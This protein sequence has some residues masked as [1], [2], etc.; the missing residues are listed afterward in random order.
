MRIS[1][2]CSMALHILVLLG[3]FPDKKS[4]S[5]QIAKSV[6]SNPVMVR[7]LLGDLRKAGLLSTQRGIGGSAL[8]KNPEEITLWM[9]YQAV[10]GNSFEDFIGLHPNPSPQCPVGKKIYSLLEEPYNKI[11]HSMREA[12]EEITLQQLLDDYNN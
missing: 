11:R 6:G 10:D 2:K 4:T 1:S 7:N 12:M 3:V 8:T 5:E 9:V